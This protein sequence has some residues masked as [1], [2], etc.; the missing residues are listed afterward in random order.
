MRVKSMKKVLFYLKILTAVSVGAIMLTGLY[1]LNIGVNIT[2]QA[3][4]FYCL[5]FAASVWDICRRIIPDVF[6]AAVLL[7]GMMNFTQDK[8]FGILLGLPLLIA[9]LIKEGG[10]GGG[11]IKLTAASGFVL[12]L[13]AGVA[14]LIFALTAVLFYHL[15]LRVI[16]KVRQKKP[17]IN[18][19]TALPLAPFLSVGFMLAHL[20]K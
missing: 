3:V 20:F 7:T 13:P 1:R 2:A 18:K 5:L 10:M 14:G 8:V 9:A 19:E 15:G 4:L 17:F 16:C 12:G 6:C 11:D